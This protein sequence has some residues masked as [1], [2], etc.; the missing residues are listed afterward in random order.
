MPEP[1]NVRVEHG[2]HPRDNRPGVW[3]TTP[4]DEFF[5]G[6]L[7]ATIPSRE[8]AWDSEEVAWW[9]SE[10]EAERAIALVV[11]HYGETIVVDEH[12]TE[13]Y[14]TADGVSA[15]QERLL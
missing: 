9:V 12:G 5:V 11:H 14:R 1:R 10:G 2:R 7:K 3:I 13:E 4:Y 15:R 6:E 8:R